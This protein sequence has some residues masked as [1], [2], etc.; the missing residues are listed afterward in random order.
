MKQIW[1][2]FSTRFQVADIY[3]Y[4][5]EPLTGSPIRASCVVQDVECQLVV[6]SSGALYPRMA[7]TV[8]MHDTTAY[9]TRI[10]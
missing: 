7:I 8:S 2:S 9:Y 4:I 10:R 6:V 5:P 3:T 1:S